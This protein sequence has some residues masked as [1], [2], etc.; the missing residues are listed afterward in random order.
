MNSYRTIKELVLETYRAEG[1]MPSYEK[2]TAL[3]REHFPTSK[4]KKTHYAWY[5]SKI[6]RGE[7]LVPGI[8]GLRSIETGVPTLVSERVVREVVP[9]QRRLQNRYRITRPMGTG[10]MGSV[11]EAID[12]RLKCLVAVKQ[13]STEGNLRA[14]DFEREASLLA[15][16][17][18]PALPR[19][20][21]HFLEADGQFLVMQHV[22]GD[23]LQQSLEKRGAPFPV[24]DVLNWANQLLDVL[25]YLHGK[26]PPVIHRDIKPSNIKIVDKGRVMLLDFGLAKGTLGQM[27]TLTHTRSIL[28]FTPIYAPFEQMFGE[29]TDPRSDIYSLG[30]TLYHLI[31]G[32][33]PIAAMVRFEAIENDR[34]DPL[35]TIR[36]L[37]PSVPSRISDVIAHA[38]AIRRKDRLQSAAMMKEALRGKGVTRLTGNR[39]RWDEASFFADASRRSLSTDQLTALR[40]LFEWSKEHADNIR[41]GDG[42]D[43]GSFNPKFTSVCPRSVFTARSD[44]ALIINFQWLTEPESAKTWREQFGHVL[45][46]KGF[47]IPFDFAKRYVRLPDKEWVSRLDDFLNILESEIEIEEAAPAGRLFYFNNCHG[48]DHVRLYGK[49]AFYDLDTTGFQSTKATDLIPGQ[50]C[51][52]ATRGSYDNITFNWYSFQREAVMNDN[53]GASCRV[54]FGDF[55]RSEELSKSE[56]AQ[57]SHYANFFDVNGNFKRHSVIEA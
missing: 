46:E 34:P 12:E 17:S 44:G 20:S 38:M 4:W 51:V 2:L 42:V 33:K 52:V 21:D 24:A 16:L 54:L 31:T 37:N 36:Q 8:S 26:E 6:K 45:K 15:N 57:H 7:I 11:Y 5:K 13:M 48:R 23:D 39:R 47:S 32:S 25:E 40:Q 43:S 22:P 35:A 56:A 30:A 50:K 9:T 10:G 29:G 41:F 14:R 19:V 27:E 28:G 55:L 1:G 3:V 49:G 53:T 18:H